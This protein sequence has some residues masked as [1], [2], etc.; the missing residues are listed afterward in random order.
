[1]TREEQYN[2][3]IAD[4]RNAIPDPMELEIQW[5]KIGRDNLLRIFAERYKEVELTNEQL[6]KMVDLDTTSYRAKFNEEEFKNQLSEAHKGNVDAAVKQLE[7]E[8][9][10]ADKEDQNGVGDQFEDFFG[11]LVTALGHWIED[12]FANDTADETGDG[13][14][15]LKALL[16]I[17]IADIE[18]YGILGGENSYL[19]KII[20]TWSDG[21]GFFGGDNSFF[22]KPFG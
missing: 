18:K 22:R 14:K 15:V 5:Y 1:M 12:R 8:R 17:S 9:D 2:Q 3:A 16:G 11:Q 6:T 7:Y 4:A 13:A 20:P 10:N 19:R 21:S